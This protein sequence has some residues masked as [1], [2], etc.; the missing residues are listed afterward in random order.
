ML[1]R[2]ENIVPELLKRFSSKNKGVVIFCL[3]VVN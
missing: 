1:Q 3:G 2:K